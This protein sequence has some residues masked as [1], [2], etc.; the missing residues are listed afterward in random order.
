MYF[1][2]GLHKIATTTTSGVSFNSLSPHLPLLLMPVITITAHSKCLEDKNQTP[3]TLAIERQDLKDR[4][5]RPTC[6]WPQQLSQNDIFLA[7]PHFLCRIHSPFKFFP[8][9]S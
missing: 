5:S 3:N 7:P 9:G 1:Q 2:S 8:Y 4:Q 6:P